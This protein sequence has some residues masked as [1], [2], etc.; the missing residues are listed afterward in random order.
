MITVHLTN[1]LTDEEKARKE[2]EEKRKELAELR[3]FFLINLPYILNSIEQK[4]YEGESIPDDVQERFTKF[5][6]LQGLE[7]LNV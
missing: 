2:L 5:E 3:A 7:E 6:Q 4:L 1:K